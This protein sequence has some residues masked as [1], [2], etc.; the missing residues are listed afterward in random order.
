MIIKL[1][2]FVLVSLA[3]GQESDFDERGFD[4]IVFGESPKPIGSSSPKPI[5]Y[6]IYETPIAKDE[7]HGNEKVR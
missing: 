4:E 3:F 1:C 6:N 5:S 7:S 2:L